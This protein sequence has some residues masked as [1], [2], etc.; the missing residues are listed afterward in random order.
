MT[1]EYTVGWAEIQDELNILYSERLSSN[2]SLWNKKRECTVIELLQE[3]EECNIRKS[4][5]HYHCAKNYELAKIGN[6]VRLILKRRDVNGTLV[7][8]VA[9]EDYM[10]NF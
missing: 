4:F 9:A 5:S 2:R 7:F 10:I 3:V 8:M 1:H 6:E